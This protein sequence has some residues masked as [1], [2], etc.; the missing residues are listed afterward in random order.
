MCT[1][2][3]LKKLN[4]TWADLAPSQCPVQLQG[5]FQFPHSAHTALRGPSQRPTCF[6]SAFSQIK[7]CQV[8]RT[9]I[10]ER[11]T[12]SRA[13]VPALRESSTFGDIFLEDELSC[14]G[15]EVSACCYL[16]FFRL[17]WQKSFLS[18]RFIWIFNFNSESTRVRGR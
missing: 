14:C 10:S 4:L 16:L 12:A 9:V 15:T 11:D 3:F 18:R 13:A 17:L 5:L 6:P 7:C 1:E 8:F 2:I